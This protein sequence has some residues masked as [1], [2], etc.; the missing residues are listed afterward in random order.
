MGLAGYGPDGKRRFGLF[1][2][3][4]VW[5]DHIANG[6]AYVAGYGWNNERIIDLSTGRIIGTRTT[7]PAPTLLL[8]L[9]NPLG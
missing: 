3:H 8:G 6:R 5:I 4:D 2:G 7:A 1:A 9:G